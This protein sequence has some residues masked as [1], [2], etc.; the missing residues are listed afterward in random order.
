[1]TIRAQRAQVPNAP[2]VRFMETAANVPPAIRTWW[3]PGQKTGWEFIYPRTQALQLARVAKQP[4]LTTAEN[5]PEPQMKTAP[6]ARVNAAGAQAPAAAEEKPAE[7]P[8]MGL[9]QRGEMTSGQTA[10]KAASPAVAAS[11]TP[12]ADAMATM[13]SS[14]VAS[15]TSPRAAT[16]VARAAT[17][18]TS[19]PQTAS[20]TPLVAFI[21]LL[22]AAGGTG[23]WFRRRHTA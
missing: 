6:L 22:A 13:P 2:E 10:S 16:Q 4:V 18:R 9:A 19:L 11:N 1:M 17:T 7:A 20:Q 5:V 15:S 12:H 3:Y 21:G 14:P 23:L 8:V